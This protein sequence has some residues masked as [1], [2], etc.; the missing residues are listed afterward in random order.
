MKAVALIGSAA[1]VG[2]L[3]TIGFGL[4]AFFLLSEPQVFERWFADYFVFLLIPVF[5]T[6]L[7]AFVGTIAM[8]RRAEKGSETRR[9][10]RTALVGL[11][12]AY[13]VT[14]VVSLP[15]N[16]A[17]WSFTLSDA[18]VT[19]GLAWWMVA[20]VARTVAALIAT[21]YAYRAALGAR[22]MAA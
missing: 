7:P 5:L 15:L 19:T 16:I 8:L 1:F 18:D 22:A 2:V 21:A 6:S 17:F 14:A 13:G 12:V 10:W 9:S 3:L 11:L 20:H 4:G